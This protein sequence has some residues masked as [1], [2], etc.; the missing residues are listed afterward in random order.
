MI[1]F[2]AQLAIGVLAFIYRQEVSL[3]LNEMSY[4]IAFLA[5]LAIDVLAIL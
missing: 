5:Q 1:A 4:M 2:L 3:L